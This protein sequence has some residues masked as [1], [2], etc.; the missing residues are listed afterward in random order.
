MARRRRK[1]GSNAELDINLTPMID[2]VFNLIIFFMVITD[3]TQKDLEFLVVP[4][5]EVRVGEA[6]V[7]EETII[8][9]VVH[10]D[11]PALEG[12]RR[13]GSYDPARP[14]I[15]LKGRQIRDLEDLRNRI[16]V[17][18]NPRLYPDLEQP[19]LAAGIRPSRWRVLIR[20]DQGQIFGWVQGVMQMLGPR[21]GVTGA[22]AVE[23]CPMIRKV[24]I[25]VRKPDD[26]R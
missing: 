22:A 16:Y 4:D 21:P 10:P 2:V 7:D 20:C 15:F 6:E 11:S 25:A 12:P 13:D 14:P 9:N 17:M 26:G 5:A 24:E 19:E 1:A 23:G 3:M 8:V 18:A